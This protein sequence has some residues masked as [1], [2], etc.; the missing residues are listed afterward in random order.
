MPVILSPLRLGQ[1]VHGMSFIRNATFRDAQAI[2]QIVASFAP[3][4]RDLDGWVNQAD[5]HAALV[6]G[7]EVIGFAARKRHKEHPTRD[8]AAFWTRSGAPDDAADLLR[9]VMPRKPR[10]LKLR[11]PS[12]DTAQLDVA[13]QLAFTE[14]IRSA[15]YLVPAAAFPPTGDAED[16]DPNRRDLAPIV[17]T[18][19]E[20]THRWDPPAPLNRRYI[21]QAM[22]NGAQAAAAVFDGNKLVGIGVAHA[23][24]DDSS[25]ADISL[26]GALDPTGPDADA[27]TA[28]LLGHLAAPYRGDRRPLWFEVD[29]GAGTNEALARLVTP[30]AA[31]NDEIVV[32]TND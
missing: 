27:I 31:P 29:T 32:L 23:P 8:L 14:R 22:L 1:T 11:F 19:Y 10:P 17:A 9:A 4:R 30:K 3:L 16:V 25:A 28:A 21:R 20:N 2:D 24:A 6:E 18:L 12:A 13:R 5:A 7:D 26:V 15:T